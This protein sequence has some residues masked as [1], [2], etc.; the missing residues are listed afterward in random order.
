MHILQVTPYF[1]PTWAYGGIPRIVDGLSRALVQKGHEVTVLT[2]DAYDGEQRSGLDG[3][4]DH[5]GVRVLTV[6][7]WSNRVKQ[8]QSAP[9][10]SGQ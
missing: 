2:T 8:S 9:N 5:H 4:R 3:D 10:E 6:R 7:N 1:P